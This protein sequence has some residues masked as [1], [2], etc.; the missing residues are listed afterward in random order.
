MI[1]VGTCK[2]RADTHT[3]VY[4]SMLF[5]FPSGIFRVAIAQQQRN[6]FHNVFGP[7]PL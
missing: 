1:G 4:M 2:L 5:F 7:K 3:Y 6:H